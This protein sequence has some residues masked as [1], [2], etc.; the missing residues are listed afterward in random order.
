MLIE[1]IFTITEE[2]ANVDQIEK[3]SDMDM[4]IYDWDFSIDENGEH[5]SLSKHH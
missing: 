2:L 5:Y 4:S 3:F 1:I